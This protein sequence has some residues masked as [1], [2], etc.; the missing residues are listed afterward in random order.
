[1][2]DQRVT[3]SFSDILRLWRSRFI[4]GAPPAALAGAASMYPA[5]CVAKS[6]NMK[7]ISYSGS[8]IRALRRIPPKTATL[9]RTKIAGCAQD[10]GSQAN[11]PKSLKG[12]EGLRLRVGNWRV[13]MDHQGNVLAV[14]DNRICGARGGVIRADYANRLLNGES[15]RRLYRDLRGMTHATLAEKAGG[16]R[17]TVA[18]IETR[19]KQGSI[20]TLC[21]L[22]DALGV[23]MDDLAEYGRPKAALHAFASALSRNQNAAAR[24]FCDLV[25]RNSMSMDSGSIG[26]CQAMPARVSPSR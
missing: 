7:Q 18:E 10:P 4:V 6:D 3:G 21:A 5:R 24:T 8:A 9:I 25:S 13:I 17:V 2:A 11:N 16:N 20:A 22:A 1:M 15:T 14:L 19:R 26:A 12:R 23:S